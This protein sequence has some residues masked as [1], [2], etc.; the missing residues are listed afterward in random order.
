M[1]YT[2]NGN[3]GKVI[4]SFPVR[5]PCCLHVCQALISSFSLSDRTVTIPE[6]GKSMI[7]ETRSYSLSLTNNLNFLVQQQISMAENVITRNS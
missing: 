4:R 1:H 6:G 3:V 2:S 5:L 7:Y